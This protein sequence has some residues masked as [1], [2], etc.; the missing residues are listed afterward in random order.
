[1]AGVSASS[2]PRAEAAVA[3]LDRVANCADPICTIVECA[4]PGAGRSGATPTASVS[5]E[6][7]LQLT[8]EEEGHRSD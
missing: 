1:M 5:Q 2:P 3:S 6:L 8:L 7:V 4:S